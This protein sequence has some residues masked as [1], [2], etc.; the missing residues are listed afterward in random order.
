MCR[1]PGYHLHELI[2]RSRLRIALPFP[3]H[4][5]QSCLGIAMPVSQ[6]RKEPRG[7][8]IFRARPTSH[9]HGAHQF[10]SIHWP[11]LSQMVT[12]HCSVGTMGLL[13]S[14][15][16]N[17]HYSLYFSYLSNIPGSSS[18]K[19]AFLKDVLRRCAS[20][21]RAITLLF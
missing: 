8:Q 21:S 2:W 15:E 6:K 3:T 16:R 9:R 12:P 18:C 5:V 1:F 20:E 14:I 19:R 17:D 4:D 10:L 7:E 13:W 11:E